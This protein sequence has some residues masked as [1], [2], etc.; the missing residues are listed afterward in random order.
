[1]CIISN[2]IKDDIITLLLEICQKA[3]KR[4]VNKK[5]INFTFLNSDISI[6]DEWTLITIYNAKSK[7]T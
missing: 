1:M 7:L 2:D 3:L 5:F 6:P 4:N